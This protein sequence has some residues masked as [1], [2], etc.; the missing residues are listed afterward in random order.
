MEGAS[1]CDLRFVR[2]APPTMSQLCRAS[3]P[4]LR[5]FTAMPTSSSWHEAHGAINAIVFGDAAD[6]QQR[7]KFHAATGAL[8]EMVSSHLFQLFT[9]TAMEPATCFDAE[10][11]RSEKARMAHCA[12]CV[13]CLDNGPC[14]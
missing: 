12:A 5:C 3:R 13:R 1:A 10:A 8:R 4:Q 11:V 6:V 7:G 2:H 14:G 9:L